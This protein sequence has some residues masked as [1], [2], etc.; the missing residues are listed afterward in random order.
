MITE[1]A[2]ALIAATPGSL[3]SIAALKRRKSN[4]ATM[5]EMKDSMALTR[6]DLNETRVDLDKARGAIVDLERRVDDCDR[7]RRALMRENLDL[8]RRLDKRD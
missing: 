8:Y 4:A 1:I 5:A 2:I 6:A 7:E 3:M